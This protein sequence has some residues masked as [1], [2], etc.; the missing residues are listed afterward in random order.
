MRD[1]SHKLLIMY[2]VPGSLGSRIPHVTVHKS[3]VCSID[4][5][6]R[7]SLGLLFEVRSGKGTDAIGDS[8][9][10]TLA[11]AAHKPAGQN[12]ALNFA[13]A[14]RKTISSNPLA[15][16]SYHPAIRETSSAVIA[17]LPSIPHKLLHRPALAEPTEF[18]RVFLADFRPAI[19]RAGGFSLFDS[20]RQIS[21]PFEVKM[22]ETSRPEET[23][24]KAELST[25][26]ERKTRTA[27]MKL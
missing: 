25:K 4:C 8:A 17:R 23:S 1:G 13:S 19:Y 22:I 15:V 16:R 11:D 21:G 9:S 12:Q 20:H 26:P 27:R 7:S 18:S 5:G 6:I 2:L 24:W 14:R 3:L 10:G